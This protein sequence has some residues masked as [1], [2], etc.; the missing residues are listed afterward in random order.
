MCLRNAWNRFETLCKSFITM[1]SVISI[2]TGGVI[3]SAKTLYGINKTLASIR[4]TLPKVEENRS[5]IRSMMAFDIDR[6]LKRIDSGGKLERNEI[7]RLRMF[8]KYHY[9][10]DKELNDLEIVL[11]HSIF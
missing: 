7:Q 2:I 1:V 6:A 3:Y 9:L 11:E 10:T 4:T 5:Y 8:K